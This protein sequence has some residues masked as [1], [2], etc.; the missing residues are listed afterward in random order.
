M[1]INNLEISIRGRL[2]KIAFSRDEWYQVIEDP[3]SLIAQLR[4]AKVNANIFTFMQRLPETKPK[5]NYYME[6]D[7]VAAIPINSFDYWWTRQIPKQVRT[8]VKKAE[9]SR[10]VV[11][12]VD[13]NDELL[14]GIMSIYNEAPIRQG[15]PFWHYGK[16][17]ETVKGE[18]SRFL[19]REDLIGAYYN[20]ELIG[21][22]FLADAGKYALTTQIISKIKDRDK[23]PTNALMAKAVEICE[24]KKLDMDTVRLLNV[25]KLKETLKDIPWSI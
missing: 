22:I 19:F 14:K 18:F 16:D 1:R 8:K 25:K 21:F 5:Y 9:K 11:K 13:L 24:K 12:V 3:E 4:E 6:W 2:I 17:F 10:V 23:S 15:K 20:D 7:N